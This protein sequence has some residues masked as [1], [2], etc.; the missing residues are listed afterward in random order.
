LYGPLSYLE[1]IASTNEWNLTPQIRTSQCSSGDDLPIAQ[2]CRF[3]RA[4][5]TAIPVLL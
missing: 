3:A 5:R 1:G 4:D 2:E